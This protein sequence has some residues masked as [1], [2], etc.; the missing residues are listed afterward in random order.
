MHVVLGLS[1]GYFFYQLFLFFRLSFFSPGS[2]TI[3]MDTL[4]AQLLIEFSTDHFETMHTCS[5]RSVDV[6]WGLSSLYFFNH[7]C[8]LST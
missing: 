6:V 3:R 4:L 2:I 1:S 8:F 7:F 5:T